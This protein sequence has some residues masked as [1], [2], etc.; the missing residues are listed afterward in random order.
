MDY[1]RPELA[2]RLAAD[3]VS[4]T[5]RGGARRRV[6]ALLPAHPVLRAAVRRWEA[7]LVPLTASLPPVPPRPE[8]WQSIA[9]RLGFAAPVAA[10]APVRWWQQLSVWRGVSAFA[11]VAA[12][13]LSAQ[14]LAPSP[15][16]PPLVV[17]LN[18]ATPA[19]D[20]LVRAS[21]VASISGDG[22]AVVTRPLTPVSLQ[23]DRALELWAVPA[24]G[25]PRSLGL[26]ASDTATVQK[27]RVPVGTAALAVSL[28]PAG[29]SPSGAPTGP[30]LYVGKLNS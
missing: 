5:L 25:A 27:G 28:E 21:F 17:V 8:V 30:V 29:G 14:L 22:R 20:G 10:A 26:I 11:T 3:Y 9:R 13:V 23:A 18:P 16:Q 12:L 19:A 7:R 6:E 1:S 4:G 2:E 24:E 15:V